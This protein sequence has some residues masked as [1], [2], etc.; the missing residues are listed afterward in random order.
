MKQLCTSFQNVLPVSFFKVL[1]YPCLIPS[2][3]IFKTKKAFLYVW[4]KCLNFISRATR[5]LSYPY[6]Y[7]FIVPSNNF[8][9]DLIMNFPQPKKMLCNIC[10]ICTGESFSSQI[11]LRTTMLVPSNLRCLR[12]LCR[13]SGGRIFD[14]FHSH[15]KAP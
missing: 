15:Y 13:K 2:S 8:K 3:F 11:N 7:H 6:T 12:H 1:E 4:P 10:K 9:R 5:I 14:C